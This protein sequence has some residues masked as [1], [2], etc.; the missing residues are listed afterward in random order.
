MNF[1]FFNQ[2]PQLL[3]SANRM[4]FS[5]RKL[6]NMIILAVEYIFAYKFFVHLFIYNIF[7]E[8]YL[9]SPDVAINSKFKL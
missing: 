4:H 1:S 6:L 2:S 8:L 7:R 9:R 5:S 3:E